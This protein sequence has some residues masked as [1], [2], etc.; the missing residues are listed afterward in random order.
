[1]KIERAKIVYVLV[2]VAACLAAPLMQIVAE[3]ASMAA[4][5]AAILGGTA[6]ARPNLIDPADYPR[7]RKPAPRPQ[8]AAMS[9]APDQDPDL[10]SAV[11]DAPRPIVVAAPA[12]WR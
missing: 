12:P 8:V 3:T 5:D 1:M 9:F 4:A 6:Q 2:A 11:R 10:R 7:P